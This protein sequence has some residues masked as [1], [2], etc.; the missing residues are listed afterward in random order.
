MDVEVDGGGHARTVAPQDQHL[1]RPEQQED[2][3]AHAT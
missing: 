1:S 3:D 2:A